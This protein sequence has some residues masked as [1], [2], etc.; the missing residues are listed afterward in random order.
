[1][2]QVYFALNLLCIMVLWV[3][4]FL[5]FKKKFPMKGRKLVIKN[6]HTNRLGWTFL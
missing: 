5:F 3:F 6:T 4:L 1:M 2:G